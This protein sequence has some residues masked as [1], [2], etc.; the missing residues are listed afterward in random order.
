MFSRKH[1]IDASSVDIV[2]ISFTSVYADVGIVF[3]NNA[4]VSHTV[5]LKSHLQCL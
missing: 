4:E 2:K 3:Q 5:G 1:D